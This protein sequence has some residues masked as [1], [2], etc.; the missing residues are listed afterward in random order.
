MAE[1]ML[2]KTWRTADAEVEPTIVLD[3][4]LAGQPMTHQ[5]M[6]NKSRLAPSTTVAMTSTLTE[7]TEYRRALKQSLI[8]S[9]KALCTAEKEDSRY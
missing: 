8:R 3:K 6:L 1:L 4:L 2:T 5:A 9:K 7:P